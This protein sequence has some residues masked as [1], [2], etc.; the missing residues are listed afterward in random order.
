MIKKF[1]DLGLQPLANNY[2]INQKKLSIKNNE[3]YKLEV[4]FDLKTKLVSISKKIPKNKMFN[5]KYPYK[6]SMSMTMTKSFKKLHK[7]I[8]KD[9]D[10]KLFLE[11]GSND[12]VFIRNFNKRKIIAVEP[13]KNLADLTKQKY[14]TYPNFWT[15]SLAKKIFLNSKKADIIFSAKEIVQKFG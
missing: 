1:L 5:N 2:L 3:L 6:S 8:I 10:P 12:G 4:F 11:I 7:D 14:K 13:C 9:F 15:I